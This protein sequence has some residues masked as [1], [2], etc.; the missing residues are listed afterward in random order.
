MSLLYQTCYINRYFS[1]LH[2][3]KNLINNSDLE[4]MFNRTSND[5]DL[6]SVYN[7]NGR[8]GIITELPQVYLA[9]YGTNAQPFV[10]TGSANIDIT[11]NQI[12]LNVLIKIIS[13]TESC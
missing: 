4:F 11:D 6:H 2:N 9:I 1:K 10:Y 5:Y 7:G 3:N 13:V 8:I 12:S